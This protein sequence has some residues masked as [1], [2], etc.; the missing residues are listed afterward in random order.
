MVR[1]GV[2][3][4]G[5]VFVSA[6]VAQEQPAEPPSQ[7][8]SDVPPAE[9]PPAPPQP[10]SW[11]EGWTGS[12]DFGI[13]GATGN[14]ETFNGRGALGL[15]RKTDRLDTKIN[16]MYIYGTD[17]GEKSESRG[18][19]GA[20]NDWLLGESPWFLF[21]L[22]RL[23]YDEFKDWDWR[24]TL[25]A[26]VGYKFIRTDSTSLMGRLG[27]AFTR[28]FG[29]TD[30]DWHIEAL[31]GGDFEHKFDERQKIF[32]TADF[33]LSLDEYPDYRF[34]VK[35][36]YEFVVDPKTKLTFKVGIEDEYDQSPGPGVRRNDFR[37]FATL[38]WVF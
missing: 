19:L 25:A 28:E 5:F 1:A 26:G 17:D 24:L 9:P 36:G 2:V 10:T 8:L 35:A 15:N 13:N 20:R 22:G 14:T 38:G 16:F 18:E 30:E 23:E 12:I 34:L 29:G 7:P 27:P 33:F 6:A 11:L 31:I 21:A 37:Y 4:A 32:A 3:I